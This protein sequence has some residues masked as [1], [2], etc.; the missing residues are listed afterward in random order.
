MKKFILTI[1]LLLIFQLSSAQTYDKKIYI[2]NGTWEQKITNT[3]IVTINSIIVKQ[4]ILTHT[5][6]EQKQKTVADLPKFRYEIYLTST[7]KQNNKLTNIF[8]YNAQVFIN[9]I[10]ITREQFPNGF[11]AIVEI[12]PT[13][14][15][16]YETSDENLNIKIIWKS[17]SFPE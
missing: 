3:T 5:N 9:D 8:I 14:I 11:T 13:L 17:I 4:K 7:S 16:W 12:E 15:Y 1:I 10:E 6:Y 2:N